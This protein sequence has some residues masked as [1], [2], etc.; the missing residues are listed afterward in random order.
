MDFCDDSPV[1]GASC[2]TS[3]N[4]VDASGATLGAVNYNGSAASSAGTI[5][6]A[7]HDI[8]W[9]AGADATAGQTV[10]ITFDG[11]TNPA[12]N[13]TVYARV[14]TYASSS[15]L[16]ASDNPTSL[17]TTADIGAVALGFT[18]S[19][20]VT[21][22]VQESMTF[23]VSGSD[24]SGNCGALGGGSA[25]AVSSPSMTLGV[26]TGNGVKAL[27]SS[28]LSTGTAYAQLSTNAAHG[29]TVNLQSDATSCG[30]LY[31]NGDTNKCNIAPNTDHTTN[32]SQ[33]TAKFGVEVGSD[34]TAVGATDATGDLTAANN[35]SSSVYYMDYQAGNAAGVTG[36]YGSA[37]FN[38]GGAPVSNK[39]IPLTVG[40]SINNN[41][42][43]GKY[44][45]TL[46]LIATGT[47]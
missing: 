27:S 13:G 18:N 40:T 35:Y 11:I 28:A 47:F 9:V 22:Y 42:P 7:A 15:D 21:A 36:P 10:D 24:V 17:G 31:L 33:G 20:G 38:S 1:I 25:V 4:D 16:P 30:G 2:G 41:T 46:R 12:T 19:I 29:A 6:A 3:T 14:Y 23:C 5:T 37:I 26:D 43:A 39:N 32:F 44:S 34:A 8:K 45:A